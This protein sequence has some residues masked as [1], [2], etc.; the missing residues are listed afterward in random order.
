[1]C[2]PLI[3]H[4]GGGAVALYRIQCRRLLPT[5][6]TKRCQ[7]KVFSAPYLC[8]VVPPYNTSR[9]QQ[10]RRKQQHNQL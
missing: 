4:S 2:N 1:M 9:R 10:H 3:D 8:T 6:P 5:D 7:D